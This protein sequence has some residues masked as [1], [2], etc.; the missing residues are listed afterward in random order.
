MVIRLKS[1]GRSGFTLLEMMIVMIIIGIL[2]SIA[3]PSITGRW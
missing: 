1:G 2:L 3:C